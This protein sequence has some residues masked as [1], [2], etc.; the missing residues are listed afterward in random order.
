MKIYYFRFKH[1]HW[2]NG[3]TVGITEGF[4]KAVDET[5][6]KRNIFEKMNENT[7]D[8]MLNEIKNNE[9]FFIDYIPAIVFK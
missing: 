3:N 4:V 2:R 5:E 8:L 1:A 7:F 6:A 9:T